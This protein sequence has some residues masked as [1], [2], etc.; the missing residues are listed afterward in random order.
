M[1]ASRSRSTVSTCARSPSDLVLSS[2][3]FSTDLSWRNFLLCLEI[4]RHLFHFG[5]KLS[6][7]DL[8]HVGLLSLELAPQHVDSFFCFAIA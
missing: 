6:I 7:H 8:L 5:L 4:S 3:K 1:E 2:F